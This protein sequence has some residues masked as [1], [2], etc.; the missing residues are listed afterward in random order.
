LDSRTEE[1]LLA[2]YHK[3][4]EL[5]ER[6]CKAIILGHFDDAKKEK[7]DAMFMVQQWF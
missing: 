3:L 6:Y 7:R 2:L 5:K 4:V 1:Q